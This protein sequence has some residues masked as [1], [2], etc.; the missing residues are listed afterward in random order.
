MDREKRDRRIKTLWGRRETEEVTVRGKVNE[1]S[2]LYFLWAFSFFQELCSLLVNTRS[3]CI[4]C[5]Q[6]FLEVRKTIL[7]MADLQRK[8]V[9]VVYIKIRLQKHVPFSSRKVT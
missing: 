1:A 3:N 5:V 6:S 4:K 7:C 9:L 8:C 2:F